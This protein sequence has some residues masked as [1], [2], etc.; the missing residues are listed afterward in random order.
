MKTIQTLQAH[1]DKDG[2]I[3]ILRNPYDA[4]SRAEAARAL[5][6]LQDMDTVESLSRS[7]LEDP[8]ETVREAA[9]SA[10][11]NIL[12]GQSDMVLESYRGSYDEEEPWLVESEE[13]EEEYTYLESDAEKDGSFSESLDE[14]TFNDTEGASVLQ[15]IRS[16]ENISA[17]IPQLVD[18]GDLEGLEKVL[19]NPYDLEQRT[20][21]AR[22]MADLYNMDA[23][24]SLARA[25]LQDPEPSVRSEAEAALKILVG[26]QS[27][28]ILDTYRSE[29][30]DLGPWLLEEPHPQDQKTTNTSWNRAD[31]IGLIMVLRH[32]SSTKIRL[33]AIKAISSMKDSMEVLDTLAELVLW[34]SDP[35]V[36]A[37]AR[38]ELEEVYGQDTDEFIKSLRTR[39]DTEEDEEDEYDEEEQEEVATIQPQPV[40]QSSFSDQKLSS[41]VMQAESSSGN[42]LIL[43]IGAIAIIA[44]VVFMIL[45]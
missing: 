10:L 41:P 16:Y 8:E 7:T 26:N 40:R 38:A 5:G 24:E 22:G 42:W 28:Y 44:L 39:P 45:R 12:G 32:E 37:A 34:S 3:R 19:R 4:L 29:L 23:V 31:M 2:L 15:K 33:K 18:V 36:K 9:R 1:Q 30:D 35:A 14:Q 11:K 6:E 25:A 43:L 13:D 21:A 20:K 27:S 17:N